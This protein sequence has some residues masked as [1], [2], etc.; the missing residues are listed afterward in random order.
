LA[1]QLFCERFVEGAIV[2][3]RRCMRRIQ[4]LFLSSNLCRYVLPETL[5]IEGLEGGMVVDGMAING[6]SLGRKLRDITPSIHDPQCSYDRPFF[7]KN[8]MVA[9][10]TKHSRT[11]FNV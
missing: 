4:T 3:W 1:S 8:L 5:I 6:A 2:D 10:K 11:F 7:K 9:I